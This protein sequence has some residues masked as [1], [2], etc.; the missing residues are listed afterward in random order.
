MRAEHSLPFQRRHKF[1]KSPAC[2][3]YTL[4]TCLWRETSF[5]QSINQSIANVGKVKGKGLGKEAEQVG[6][7]A[8]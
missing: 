5:K 6:T 1:G 2:F 7:G 3:G 4:Y 8:P